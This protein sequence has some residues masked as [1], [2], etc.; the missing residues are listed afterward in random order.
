MVVR[1]SS[2]IGAN[3]LVAVLAIAPA[4]V[5]DS[6]RAHGEVATTTPFR[7]ANTGPA[8][9]ATY[10]LPYLQMIGHRGG[11]DWAPEN[12]LA[13]LAH[14]FTIGARA[15]EFDVHFS[16]DQTPMVMHDETL[17]RTTNCTGA[18][19]SH[20]YAQLRKCV[21][22]HGEPVP[23]IYEALAVVARANGS[24]YVHIKQVDN[25]AQARSIVAAMN[26]YGV[27][28]GRTA[29][30]IA[31]RTAFLDR[32][33]KAGAKRCGLIFSN[34]V[35]WRSRYPVLIPFNT[36]ITRALVARAQRTGHFVVAVQNRPIGVLQVPGL[37]L[38]GYMAN[39]LTYA[40]D[41]LAAER[42]PA[43]DPRVHSESPTSH[44]Y[45]ETPTAPQRPVVRRDKDPRTG[46]AGA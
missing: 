6:G 42:R 15:V 17:D 46:T 2:L 22:K 45:T 18:V 4:V 37:R 27:N 12:T 10:N 38:D 41:R 24:V 11:N 40:L 43:A 8:K 20:T 30:V 1:R 25:A 19:E 23:N 3:L 34:P 14:S 32:L 13:G 16:S 26:R 5:W 33:S 39:K 35:Y 31:D 21:T 36:K 28:D 44:A 29:T 7:A 9:P